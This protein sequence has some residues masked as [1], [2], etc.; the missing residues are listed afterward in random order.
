MRKLTVVA[1]LL[2]I[3]TAAVMLGQ[4]AGSSDEYSR[5]NTGWNGTSSFFGQI[6]DSQCIWDADSLTG[7]TGTLLLVISPSHDFTGEGLSAYLR[8]GNTILLFDQAGNANAFL[9]SLGSSITVHD[10][11]VRSSNME[12]K[13]AGLFR[14]DVLENLF[15]TNVTHLFFNYPGYVTGGETVIQTS[16]LSWVDLD[17]DNTADANEPLKVYSLAASD[18]IGNGRIV[19]VADPSLFVNSMLDRKH[20]ENM[21]VLE[22]LLQEEPYIYL[23]GTDVENGSGITGLLSLLHRYPGAGV[24]LF[25]ILFLCGGGIYL[26]RRNKS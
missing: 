6:P 1:I 2:L 16:P 26:W 11:E 25:G 21:A 4:F 17:G 7:K 9:S 12:Y 15:G 3:L 20:T 18:T 24:G 10:A 13:D 22:A 8:A 23:A 5:Y 19:V 14:A